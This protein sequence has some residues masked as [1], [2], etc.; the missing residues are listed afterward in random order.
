MR[1]GVVK[2]FLCKSALGL[3]ARRAESKTHDTRKLWLSCL[4]GRREIELINFIWLMTLRAGLFSISHGKF[5]GSFGRSLK[6]IAIWK[7]GRAL[8]LHK[9]VDPSRSFCIIQRDENLPNITQRANESQHNR[10]QSSRPF[11]PP[12][13]RSKSLKGY[14]IHEAFEAIIIHNETETWLAE[15]ARVNRE[16]L[17]RIMHADKEPLAGKMETNPLKRDL[18]FSR[19]S[20][21]L[22]AVAVCLLLSAR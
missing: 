15:A 5:C 19:I 18:Q 9:F 11:S 6:Q 8:W 21:S 1:V 20:S 7:L 17:V 14:G 22:P 12:H 10:V 2:W 13:A 3:F 4:R 16:L